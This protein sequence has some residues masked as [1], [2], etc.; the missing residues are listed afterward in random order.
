MTAVQ[1]MIIASEKIKYYEQVCRLCEYAGYESTWRDKFW[2]DLLTDEGI[3][4]E[5][6]YYLE[7]Q[8]FLGSCTI[9]GYSVFDIFIWQMR[10]YNIRVD[11]G[12][13]G[14]DC[15]KM[16]MLLETF[17]TMLDMKENGARIEWSM[18]MN[19]GMDEL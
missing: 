7:H 8:D 17:R 19:N 15:D 6:L 13:N 11:R 14:P 10:R 9:D 12:K 1:P 4:R 3:D 18:E 2:Q 16:A 5:L